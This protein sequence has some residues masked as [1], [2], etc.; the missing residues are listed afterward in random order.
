MKKRRG[1]KGGQKGELSDPYLESD[2]R[3][4]AYSSAQKKVSKILTLP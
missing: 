4:F 1:K 2:K 3:V